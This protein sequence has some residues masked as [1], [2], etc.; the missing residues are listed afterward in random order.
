MRSHSPQPALSPGPEWPIVCHSSAANRDASVRLWGAV[1]LGV[2]SATRSVLAASQRPRKPPGAKTIRL[3]RRLKGCRSLGL[4]FGW[5]SAFWALRPLEG[6]L[7]RARAEAKP[8][9]SSE[10]TEP[11]VDSA[12]LSAPEQKKLR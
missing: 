11:H 7:G 8:L 4:N 12:S 3:L 9:F 2:L 10:E 5:S 6:A 1:A